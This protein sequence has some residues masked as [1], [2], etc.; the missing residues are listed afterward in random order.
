[1]SGIVSLVP[2]ATEMIGALGLLDQLVAVSHECDFPEPVKHLPRATK[3]FMDTGGLGSREIDAEIR[4]EMERRGT[5]YVVDEKLLQELQPDL[6]LTQ[7]LCDVCAVGYES[8]QDLASALPHPAQVLYLEAVS[9]A[10][11]LRDVERIAR[12]CGVAERG[13]QLVRALEKRI[14][15]VRRQAGKLRRPRCFVMEWADPVFGSGHWGPELVEIAGGSE[16]LG[17]KH[18]PSAPIAWTDVVEAQPEVMVL[19]LCGYNIDRARRDFEVVRTFPGFK[20]IPAAQTRDV[21]LVDANSYFTRPGPRI[22]DTLE[23]LAGI[24]HP[25][26]FPGFVSTG[27]NDKRVVRTTYGN[28]FGD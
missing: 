22:V 3:C 28:D 26:E 23:I 7:G 15:S 24:F 9:L 11:I 6:I 21:Y 17:R 10:D 19:A 1:M 5:I 16:L 8:V 2:A 25:L 20:S 4:A 18:L 14:E 13:E 12:V 27:E